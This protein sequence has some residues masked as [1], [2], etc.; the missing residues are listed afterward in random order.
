MAGRAAEYGRPWLCCRTILMR[1]MAAWPTQLASAI[2]LQALPVLTE[3]VEAQ[4]RGREQNHEDICDRSIAA[5]NVRH[6]DPRP[7]EAAGPLHRRRPRS[8]RRM[9]TSRFRRVLG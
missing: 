2:Y 7:G 5:G 8:G 3:A 9:R 6:A 1:I 4:E